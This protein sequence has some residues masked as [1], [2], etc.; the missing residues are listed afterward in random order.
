MI[1][2]ETRYGSYVQKALPTILQSDC[3]V[4]I[5]MSSPQRSSP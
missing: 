4:D 3:A 2:D 1:H 5:L